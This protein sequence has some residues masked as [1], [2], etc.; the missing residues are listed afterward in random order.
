VL[1]ASPAVAALGDLVARLVVAAHVLDVIGFSDLQ[2]IPVAPTALSGPSELPASLGRAVA[3]AGAAVYAAVLMTALVMLVARVRA[4]PAERSAWVLI[5]AGASV[6]GLCQLL[7]V[8]AGALLPTSA[9]ASGNTAGAAELAIATFREHPQLAAAGLLAY[10]LLYA[11]QMRL[12]KQHVNGVLPSAWLDGLLAGLLLVAGACAFAAPALQNRFDLPLVGALALVLRPLFD[13]LLT[14]FAAANWSLVGRGADRR[15]IVLTAAFA[16]LMAA[17]TLGVARV[18]GVLTVEL[19]PVLQPLVA[20]GALDS[21]ANVVANTARLVVLLVLV[22]VATTAP[23]HRSTQMVRWSSIAGPA[24]VMLA[25]LGLLWRNETSPLGAVAV[26]TALLAVA[27]VGVKGVLIF[28][29]VLA[30]ADSRRLAL[31]DDLTGL[32]NRRALHTA[33]VTAL[34]AALR[35]APSSSL[36]GPL[37][38]TWRVVPISRPPA[39]GEGPG[40]ALS[41]LRVGED[42]ASAVGTRRGGTVVPDEAVA[43]LLVDLNGFKAVNDRYGHTTGDA[44]LRWA[45]ARLA[46]VAPAGSVLARL[47]GDEFALLL[48]G[49]D[50]LRAE[51]I[52][53]AGATAIAIAAA[54]SSAASAVSRT[55]QGAADP[56]LRAG[57]GA[58]APTRAARGAQPEALAWPEQL[59][60]SAALTASIGVA[61]LALPANAAVTATG[62]T[63]VAQVFATATSDGPDS[64]P[65]APGDPVQAAEELLRRADVAMYRAKTS[66]EAVRVYDP[67]D[68]HASQERARLL[69]ELRAALAG[70][71][72]ESDGSDGPGQSIGLGESAT[73][74]AA[75]STQIVVHYQPQID[76]RTGLVVGVEALVRWRH[77][78]L[79][80][81]APAAFLDLAEE[82][83]LVGAITTRVLRTAAADAARWHAAGHRLRVAVNLSTSCL[84]N[85]A[86][87]PLLDVVLAETGLDPDL[88]VMEVTETTLM[89]DP[90]RALETAHGIRQRGVQLSIDDYG[91]GYSSL[92]YLGS[93][94]A[95]EL[96]LD[97]AFTVRLT[98]DAATA[99]IVA[100]TVDLAHRLGLRL[101]AEGVEDEATLAALAAAGCD[102]SQGY[103]HARPEPAAA[104][105]RR[106]VAA[107]QSVVPPGLGSTT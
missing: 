78:R 58:G 20:P 44:L 42:A 72:H 29:E 85:P 38:A 56:R 69:E 41:D 4:M 66:G 36:D 24:V 47:G 7:L 26:A 25:A 15:L 40:S 18:T 98:H 23:V 76:L 46:A 100:S 93:L 77:P 17:D 54:G 39:V 73:A 87:L 32:A 61:T 89:S 64:A 80:L 102:E 43:L 19:G 63:P 33:L 95:T 48:T 51:D 9:G 30:L 83:G 91:T 31:S 52:A 22:S 49:N 11:G 67:Q 2:P 104:V 105:S 5:T 10:P 16:L 28:Q 12:L 92:A 34:S 57:A 101:L 71:T 62:L 90:D 106:L 27:G 79:G 65:G 53:H 37:D 70:D 59:P 60:L 97:R 8:G 68:D 14:L 75:G 3:V 21:V 13:L 82:H 50:A 103:F 6:L 99:A 86:L 45:A 1:L 94:P 81:L 96:K 74:E 107:T 84:V 88:L 35:A 55:D